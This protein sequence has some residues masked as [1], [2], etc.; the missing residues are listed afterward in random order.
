MEMRA[1]SEELL[2]SAQKVMGDMLDFAVN[3]YGFDADEFF[4]MF[5]ISDVAEQFE[6]GNTSYIS[7]KTGCELV[8][9]IIHKSG[10]KREELPDEMYLD[11]SPEYWAGW[12]FAYYQWFT[13]KSFMRIHKA[14]PIKEILRMYPAF[15]E[16][17]ITQFVDAMNEKIQNFYTETNLKRIR[18]YAGLS[19]K[20]LSEI[21]GVPIRQIQL[22][23]QRQRDI[24][25]AQALSVAKL[26]RALGC[27][28]EAL[29]EI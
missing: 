23:E 27:R 13:A 25:K 17:D 14:V 12:A 9:E 7:G 15:H 19:Q 22:F 1:Y 20:E 24:N 6:I 16:M 8:K 5:V 11:K 21:S 2:A 29:L 10:L 28:S 18:R 26:G 4:R 3:S